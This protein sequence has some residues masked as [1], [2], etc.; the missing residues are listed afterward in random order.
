MELYYH[1]LLHCVSIWPA[2]AGQPRSSCPFRPVGLTSW[3][4]V[5]AE[6]LDLLLVEQELGDPLT[7]PSLA[8]PVEVV[9]AGE[10]LRSSYQKQV[11]VAALVRLQH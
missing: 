11:E 1:R 10:Q 4:L 6:E 9:E 5:V 8:E 3:E 2:A 7:F